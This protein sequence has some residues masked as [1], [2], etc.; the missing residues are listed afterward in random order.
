MDDHSLVKLENIEPGP[1]EF[2]PEVTPEEKK[3]RTLSNEFW[4]F[5]PFLM[6]TFDIGIILGNGKSG[7]K[8][9]LRGH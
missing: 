1:P 2:G 7:H 8:R 6:N 3:T 9:S 5:G 4:T